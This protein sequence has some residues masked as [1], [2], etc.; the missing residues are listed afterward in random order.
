MRSRGFSLVEL[1]VVLVILSLIAGIFVSMFSAMSDGQRAATTRAKL[2]AIDAALVS[3][4]AIHRRLPC[5]ANG[6]LTAGTE[7]FGTQDDPCSNQ[8]GGVVPWVALGLSAA[9]IEDGWATRITYRMDPYLARD[10]AMDMSLCDPAGTGTPTT[11]GTPPRAKCAVAVGTCTASDLSKCV[12]PTS[13]LAGKGIEIRD[14]KNGTVLM[15]PAATPSTGA[16]YVLISHGE[17][18]AGGYGDSGQLLATVK[19]VEGA[20]E[21]QNRADASNTH[22]VDAPQRFSDDAGRFDD[23]V[24]RPTVISVIQRAHLGPRSH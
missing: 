21:T 17:N 10:G 24:I 9:D 22:Y 7:M 14:S 4:V 5:P 13:F 1:T 19:S 11:T 15:N 16:A 3:F 6:T 2:A 18:R 23:F 8:A 20:N 12:N